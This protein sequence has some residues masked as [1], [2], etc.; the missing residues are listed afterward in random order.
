MMTVA[1]RTKRVMPSIPLVSPS[2]KVNRR[3]RLV[4][5]PRVDSATSVE[6]RQPHLMRLHHYVRLA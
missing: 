2:L 6:W 3:N 4:S 5:F 1:K